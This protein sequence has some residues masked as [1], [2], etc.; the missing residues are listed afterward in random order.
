MSDMPTNESGQQPLG[1][2]QPEKKKKKGLKIFLIILLSLLGLLLAVGIGAVIFMNSIINE[3]YDY[4]TYD[5]GGLE[6]SGVDI[7]ASD[8]DI[9]DD[10]G[11]DFSNFSDPEQDDS[12]VPDVSYDESRPDI[13]GDDDY[14]GDDDHD[15]GDDDDDDDYVPPPPEPP[16][17]PDYE[18]LEG[19]FD[20]DTVTEAYD[21]DVINILLIGADTISGRSARSDTMILMSV[22]NVKKRIVFTSFMRDTY[23]SIPGYKDNRLNAAFAA[24]GPNLLIRTIKQNFDIDVDFYIT[25]SIS[26]FEMAVDVIGGIDLTINE[27]NYDYFKNWDGIKGLSQVEATDGTHTVHLSGGSALGYARSRNFSNGD[28]T[29]TLHQRDLLKQVAY[30]CKSLSLSELHSLM[31]AVLPYVVTNIPKE[32]LKSMIWNVLTYV[33]YDITDARVPCPGS[34]QYARINNREV[35]V[36]NFDA[37]KRFVKAKIY[38]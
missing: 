33:T 3:A 36:V 23:V 25:V 9:D 10:M 15:D 20:G 18:I 31:K 22:N 32:T 13:S 2:E 14:D 37:N 17:Q 27:T 21:K 11:I 8:Y 16:F 29:R 7:D 35:L 38:G 34:F 12:S 5:S 30:S 4:L 19:L 6:W 28:F 26:S 24:G 1:T